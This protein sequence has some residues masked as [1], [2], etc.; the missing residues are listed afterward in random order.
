MYFFPFKTCVDRCVFSIKN[1][2]DNEFS[3]QIEVIVKVHLPNFYPNVLLRTLEWISSKI[4]Q[5]RLERDLETLLQNVDMAVKKWAN[6]EKEKRIEESKNI[7]ITTCIND[8]FSWYVW[9]MN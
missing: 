6:S 9:P 4:I 8:G 3:G 1:V 2:Q 7:N 5:G